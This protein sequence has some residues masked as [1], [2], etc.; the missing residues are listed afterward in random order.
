MINSKE[1]SENKLNEYTKHPLYRTMSLCVGTLFAIG[2][3]ILCSEN[4]VFM[5]VVCTVCA[6]DMVKGALKGE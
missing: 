6:Y 5:G 3:S 2:G 1:T 4:K